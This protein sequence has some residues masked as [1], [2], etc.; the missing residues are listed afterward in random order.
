M[1]HGAGD[2]GQT[3]SCWN[4]ARTLRCH[5]QLAQPALPHATEMPIGPGSVRAAGGSLGGG[6]LVL[7]SACSG[8]VWNLT[9][10]VLRL[11]G[12]VR[13]TRGSFPA[14]WGRGKRL[15]PQEINP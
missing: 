4:L 5:T 2:A 12:R 13:R 3:G 6:V 11:H 10:K 7:L 1:V 15:R 9:N 8:S 14:P